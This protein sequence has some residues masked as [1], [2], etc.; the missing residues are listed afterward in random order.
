MSLSLPGLFF[1]D[2]FDYVLERGRF[3]AML[4]LIKFVLAEVTLESSLNHPIHK[5]FHV[6]ACKQPT[7]LRLVVFVFFAESEGSV[8][9]EKLLAVAIARVCR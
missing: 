8:F 4:A 5:N 3:P 2:S 9:P 1:T 6:F 7:K